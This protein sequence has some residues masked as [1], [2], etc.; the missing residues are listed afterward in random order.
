LEHE[1]EPAAAPAAPIAAPATAGAGPPLAIGLALTPAR[2][3]ALQR[4]A[5]NRAV[6][7]LLQRDDTPKTPV[8]GAGDFG[9]SGGVP[10]ATGTTRVFPDADNTVTIQAPRV[11]LDG[12]AWVKDGKELGGS[13]YLGVIQ[14]LVSSDRATVYRHG[15]DPNGDIVAEIHRGEA[16]KWDAA[17][18]PA[19]KGKTAQAFAPFYWQPGSID[20]TNTEKTPAKPTR[21]GTPWDQPDFSMKVNNGPGRVTQ[22]K[23]HDTF[24][25]GLAVKK[26][27]TV[28]ML[29]GT[30]WTV[31]WDAQ[32]D[33]SLNGAGKAVQT[34]AIQ[35]LLK[36]GPDASLKD[37]S[38]ADDAGHV[39][40]GFS[41][42]AE[43]M[44]RTPSQLLNWIFAAREHDQTSYQNICTALDSM[45]PTL[46][47]KIACDTTDGLIGRD[48]MSASVLRNGALVKSVGNIQ[49]KSGE[50]EELHLSWSEAMG[51]A[52]AL[53]PGT[54]MT[55]VLNVGADRL[56]SAGNIAFPFKGSA[57]LT[58]GTG[59]YLV[60]L[61]L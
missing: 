35:D 33:A 49:L 22:F 8:A 57:T 5:G 6:A 31:S 27:S 60:S 51:S 38:L 24:K 42:P 15:G 47:V 34:Q 19:T 53:T 16:N 50:S 54:A 32:V 7:N 26:D 4:T 48:L 21:L 13:A 59:K 58:P 18:D 39:F 12:Q 17:S 1:L 3:L 20:D 61:S 36:D 40:E 44:K 14:N 25:M 37:W 10:V 46:T 29:T 23:G 28:Y 11:E 41:T 30:E 52:A 56:E 45:N 9:V 55:V 2:V 43:A